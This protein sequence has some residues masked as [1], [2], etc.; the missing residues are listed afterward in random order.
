MTEME[1][2]RQQM[3]AEADDRTWRRL[4]SR[5]VARAEVSDRLLRG[6]ITEAEAREE[7]ARIGH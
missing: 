7:V 3:M 5:A 1:A 6:E 4:E 2:A